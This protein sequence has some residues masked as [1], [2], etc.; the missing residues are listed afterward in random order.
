[1]PSK[2]MKVKMRPGIKSCFPFFDS[3][4][5][6]IIPPGSSLRVI[7]FPPN[8]GHNELFIDLAKHSYAAHN[9]VFGYL[10]KRKIK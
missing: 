7:F 1:M 2:E 3:S 6:E 4:L 5:G 8:T 10:A 9:I